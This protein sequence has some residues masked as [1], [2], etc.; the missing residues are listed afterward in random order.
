MPLTAVRV[1]ASQ[2]GPLREALAFRTWETHPS[3]WY[4]LAGSPGVYSILFSSPAHFARPVVLTHVPFARDAEAVVD[5]EGRFDHAVMDERSWDPEPAQGYLQPFVARGASVTHVGFRLATDG[6]DGGG[7]GHRTVLVSVHEI[8]PGEPSTW[9]RRGPV[10]VVVRVD[11]GG[12]KGYHHSVGWCS[13]EVPTRPG[14]RYAVWLRPEDGG[15]FQTFWRP[16]ADGEGAWR[17]G[18]DGARRAGHDV[19]MTV[20]GDGDG[21]VIPYAKRVHHKFP[22]LTRHARRWSQTWVARGR[23][24]AGAV[25]YAAT[26]GTQP[27]LSRQRVAVRIRR[28]GPAGPQVG[29]EKIAVG[30]GNWTGDASWGTFGLAWAPG[31]VPLRPG[32]LY[33]LEFESIETVETLDGYVNIK[34]VPSD[35]RPGFNPY[36]KHERDDEPRGTAYLDGRTDAG[37]DLDLQIVEY[38]SPSPDALPLSGESLLVNGAMDRWATSGDDAPRLEGWTPFSRSASARHERATESRETPNPVARVAAAKGAPIDAGW[39]Q[40]VVDLARSEAYVLSG[41]LRASWPVDS[42]HRARVGVDPTGQVSD[43]EADTVRW[44]TLPAIHGVFVDFE[45]PPARPEASSLSV[46]LRG[47]RTKDAG[48]PFRVDFDRL[49]LRRVRTAP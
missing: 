14:A 47:E 21:L 19:W 49:E 28:G 32:E 23:G 36:R 37:F 33:A 31:E 27:P 26:S 46:W 5:V 41:R 42:E 11:C 20:D 39:T 34:G 38:E 12:P 18:D 9:P 13:G 25:L 10:G 40:R 4:R 44:L 8:G 1:F 29:P 6:V 15:T 45:L 35:L 48:F 3:G 16:A 22:S 2:R 17:V 7:P 43:P 30:N 24:L